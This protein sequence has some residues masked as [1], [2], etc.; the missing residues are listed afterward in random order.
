PGAVLAVRYRVG[1]GI[2]GNVGADAIAHL[3]VCDGD[4]EPGVR[5]VRNPLPAAGGTDPEPVEQVRQLAPLAL[6]RRRLRA[7]TA[8]DYAELA[9]AVPGVQ[10]A[11]AQLR[12]TGSGR[13]AHVAVDPLGTGAAPPALL[14]RVRADLER[15]RRIGH[16][17]VVV[18]ATRVPLE[19]ALIVCVTPGHHRQRVRDDIVRA[20]RALFAPDAVT[21]AEP[22]RASRIV[23]AAAAVAGV[24]SVR[25]TRLRRLF[26][27]DA[28][29]LDAGVLHVG[30]LEVA[31]LDDD[32]DRPEA[33]RLTVTTGGG[34]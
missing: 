27:P 4:E 2:A 3:V 30:P 31:Q 18:P 10:R 14:E 16:D 24:T 19:V 12:W 13:Q 34:S 22:V 26:R 28:G 6:R 32:P 21:F 25:V 17:L 20:V 5:R 15:Y 29:E 8:E 23:A 33:G 9:S 7:V 1:S 11:A